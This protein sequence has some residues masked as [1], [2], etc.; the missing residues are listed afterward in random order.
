GLP[1]FA[2]GLPAPDTVKFTGNIN[3]ATLDIA[4]DTLN[5][6]AASYALIAH[7]TGNLTGDGHISLNAEA[8]HDDLSPLTQD[9]ILSANAQATVEGPLTGPALDLA[10]TIIPGTLKERGLSDIAITVK[11]ADI[12]QGMQGHTHVETT[13]R[14]QPVMLD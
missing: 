4:L 13:Y 12:A 1:E 9:A 14:E 11:T 8:Q 7:G 10:A 2:P 6:T 3:P 5:V